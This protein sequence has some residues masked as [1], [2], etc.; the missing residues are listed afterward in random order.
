[1]ESDLVLLAQRQLLAGALP[2]V[3]SFRTWGGLG[4]GVP[5][6]LCRQPI[7]G[8]TIEIEVVWELNGTDQSMLMHFKCQAAWLAA[9]HQARSSE[10]SDSESA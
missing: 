7:D 2:V 4:T 5:C 6:A 10:R 9:L 1:V 8:S 3:Q